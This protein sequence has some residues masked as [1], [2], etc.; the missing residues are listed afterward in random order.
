MHSFNSASP[1]ALYSHINPCIEMAPVCSHNLQIIKGERW[2]G[3]PAA[4]VHFAA[5][6]KGLGMNIRGVE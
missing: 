5:V 6:S 1:L 4:T 2:H 3:S